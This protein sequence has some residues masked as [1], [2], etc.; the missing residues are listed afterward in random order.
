MTPTTSELRIISARERSLTD[1]NDL[2]VRSKSYWTWPAGY[3]EK[4]LPLHAT[5]AV[6]LRSNEC[7]EVLDAGRH[8]AFF[9]IAVRE[10]RLVLDNLWVRPD[11][12][13]SGVGRW[14]CEH[15]FR[16]ARE[17][18]WT[19]LWVVPDPPAAG[20]Y[21][22]MGFCDTGERNRLSR[23]RRS[24]LRGLPC[25]GREVTVM[26]LPLSGTSESG[27]HVSRGFC[28]DCGSPVLARNDAY[29]V[30][31]IPASSLD[32]PSCHRARMDVW[33]SSAQPW[34]YMNPALPKY[35][36]GLEQER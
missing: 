12:I 35:P 23:A 19:S 17:H 9:A 28:P 32:D 29:P 26:N 27:H 8:A 18:G 33:T 14:A 15:V 10:A 21:A 34:D 13:R 30:Y 25:R 2:I 24:G 5:D 3:L 11:L 31:F 4:A 16:W 7:F 1:I 22:Q 20:F 36:K 6:Y